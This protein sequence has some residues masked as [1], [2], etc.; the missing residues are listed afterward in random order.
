[1]HMNPTAWQVTSSMAG[2]VSGMDKA[3][4]EM[5]VEKVRE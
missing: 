1:M 3:L 4:K 5:D 2:I